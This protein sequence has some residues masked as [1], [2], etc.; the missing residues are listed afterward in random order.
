MEHI[1]KIGDCAVCTQ[2]V[3]YVD[4]I[5]NPYWRHTRGEHSHSAHPI[6][7]APAEHVPEAPQD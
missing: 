2:D 3:E 7:T 6:R 4:G 1:S 5:P